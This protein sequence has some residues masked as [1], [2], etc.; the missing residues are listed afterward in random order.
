MQGLTLGVRFSEGSVKREMTILT[1]Q[2][3]SLSNVGE[4]NHL[5]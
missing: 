1:M 4:V 3:W 2:K 5:V